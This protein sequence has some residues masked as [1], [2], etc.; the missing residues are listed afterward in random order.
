M[1]SRRQCSES[2]VARADAFGCAVPSPGLTCA[3][4]RELAPLAGLG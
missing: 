2:R 3:G 1:G 4:S